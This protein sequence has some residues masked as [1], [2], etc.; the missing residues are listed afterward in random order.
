[1]GLIAFECNTKS[2]AVAIPAACL[3]GFFF[4]SFS[5]PSLFVD[6]QENLFM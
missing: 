2:F 3:F 1:M 4:F 5:F 6:G